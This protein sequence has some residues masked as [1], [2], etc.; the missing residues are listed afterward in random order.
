MDGWDAIRAGNSDITHCQL[1]IHGPAAQTLS[2]MIMS[3]PHITNTHAQFHSPNQ[4]QT[5]HEHFNRI[6]EW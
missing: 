4:I 1:V 5:Q 2:L 6:S 3:L